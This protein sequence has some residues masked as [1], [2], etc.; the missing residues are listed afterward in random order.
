MADFKHVVPENPISGIWSSVFMHTSKYCFEII[1]E[2]AYSIE[3]NISKQLIKDSVSYNQTLHYNQL[4]EL[5]RQVNLKYIWLS[6]ANFVLVV[7]ARFDY[8]DF[9]QTCMTK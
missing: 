5:S 8:S 6:S 3:I 1:A 4:D 2:S 7:L 9:D